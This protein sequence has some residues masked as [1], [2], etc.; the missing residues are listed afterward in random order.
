MSRFENLAGKIAVVTGGA[1]GIG[2]GIASRL[3]AQGM[4]V[5]IADVEQAA[6]DSTASALGATGIRVDV[7]SLEASKVAGE[8][9]ATS[10]RRG[11]RRLSTT[12]RRL[13]RTA[14]R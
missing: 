3:I 6:L 10:F 9:G 1:S 8:R 13:G 12:P 2:R 5:V 7:S 14:G 11:V 4:R